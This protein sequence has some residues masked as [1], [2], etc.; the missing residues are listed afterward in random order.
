MLVAVS[1][2]VMLLELLR[3]VLLVE[4]TTALNLLAHLAFWAATSFSSGASRR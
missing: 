4:T 1:V 3:E 2:L